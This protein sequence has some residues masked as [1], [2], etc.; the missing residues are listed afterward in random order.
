MAVNFPNNPVD[1]TTHTEEGVSWVFRDPPGAWLLRFYSSADIDAL[2]AQRLSVGGGALAGPLSIDVDADAAM[3]L[4]SGAV[5]Y[6]WGIRVDQPWLDF[7]LDEGAGGEIAATITPPGTDTPVATGVIT[8]EKG[9]ERFAARI[10]TESHIA[11]TANPHQTSWLNL[12]GK[13]ATFPPSGHTHTEAQIVDLDKYTQGEVETRLATRLTQAQ[14]DARVPVI[15]DARYARYAGNWSPGTYSA[16]QMVSHLE[17]TWLAVVPSTAAEP[18]SN[19]DWL[20][21]GAPS[22]GLFRGNNGQ[23]GNSVSGVGDIIRV[24]ADRLTVDVSI[25]SGENASAA[26]PLEVA[27]GVTLTVNAGGSLVIV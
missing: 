7:R 13:P 18:G 2:L 24:N 6:D 8:R 10:P 22:G 11:S 20:A 17:A 27:A 4:V 5:V 26:G 25:N 12:I 3:L 1:G 21:V 16:N 14:V 15:G 9:D 23:V 19:A